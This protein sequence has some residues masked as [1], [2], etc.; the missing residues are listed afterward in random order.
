MHVPAAFRIDDLATLHAQIERTPLATLVSH[1]EQGLHAS[2]LPLLL[3][4]QQGERGTLHGHFARANPQW[5]SLAAGA[6]VL[7]VFQGPQAYVSPSFYPS[8]AVDHRAVPTW[9]Y[10]T[11]HAHGH[12][13]LYDDPE[14]LRA[15]LASLTRHHEQDRAQPWS[16]DDAPADYLAGMLRAIVG[17]S[18]PIERLEGAWKL[19]QNH[20]A[21]NFHGVQQHLASSPAPNEQA[22]A[23]A[24]A[25]L[26]R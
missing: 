21:A 16:L 24:M 20:D 6:P 25:A 9:N 14:R 12:A 22:V 13:E 5:R 8:K 17:F 23:Q 4:R 3:K 2:H 10:V 18:L 1:D 26:S 7:L 15:L 11:V 19:S